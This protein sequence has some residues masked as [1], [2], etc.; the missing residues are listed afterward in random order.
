MPDQNS[1]TATVPSTGSAPAGPPREPSEPIESQPVNTGFL[2]RCG[3]GG[4]LMGLANLVPGISGG[5][6]LLASGVYPRFIEAIGD[7]TTLRLR[8]GSLLTLAAVASAALVAIVLLAGPVKELVVHQRWIMYSLFIG[9]TLGGVPV[10]WRMIERLTPPVWI[11]GFV[12]L[13]GMIGLA[14]AQSAGGQGVAREGFLFMLLAGAAGA[15]A[16]ILPG[17]SG[18]YLLLVLGVYVPVL[19]GIATLKAAVGARDVAAM[20]DV[21]LAVILPIGLGVLIGVVA[22][23]N[24]LKWLLRRFEK[25]TLGVLLGLLLGAVAGLWPFQHGVAPTPGDTLKNQVVAAADDGALVFAETGRPVEPDDYP[26]AV[27]TPSAGQVGLSLVI[28]LAGLAVTVAIDRF[29]RRAAEPEEN[30]S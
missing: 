24:L 29:G 18:G 3:I 7:V 10:I 20:T 13:I 5:T 6:M 11:G 16:M 19:A 30:R 12:G 1:D 26:T 28:I 4:T 27:F 21:T 15:S 2:V 9:L 17:V 23:S 22:V 8:R 14:L 25:A